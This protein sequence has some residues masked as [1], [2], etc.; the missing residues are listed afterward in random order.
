MS[1]DADTIVDRR[2]MRR[3]LTRWRIA[4]A[5]LAIVAV[6]GAGVL[7]RG[8]ANPI[9]GVSGQIAR[10]NIEGLIRSDRQRTEAL[11]RLGRS[12]VQAV[13]VRIN[14]PG[15]TVAGS[16]QLYESL[17]RL[18]QQKPVVIVIDGLAASG[19]YIAAMAGDHIVAQQSAIVGSI[20]VLFQYPNVSELLG[21]IGVKVEAVRSSPLKAMPSPTEPSTPESVAAVEALVM[22]SYNWF[23]NLVSER[24]K[25]EGPGLDT[26]ADGRVFT[27]RQALKL[28]LIDSLG[29]ER[30]ALQW[31]AKTHK[32]DADTP[33]RDYRLDSRLSDLPFLRVA[34]ASALDALGL[35]AVAG[36]LEEWGA[37]QAVGRLNLDGLLALWHP[38]ASN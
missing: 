16:E 25:L 34:T 11:D 4:A 10:V 12:S 7:L 20:G 5:L 21:N 27:G 2:R 31:L 30:T 13:V 1:Y 15:G 9:T 29:N 36:R 17:A 28:G 8:D 3:K 18:K 23:R 26:V 37:L 32:I 38:P 19:G 24:R 14:S 22:D 33:V 6:V 35:T